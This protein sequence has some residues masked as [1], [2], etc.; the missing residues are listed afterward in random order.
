[1][2]PASSCFPTCIARFQG[3]G[4]SAGRPCGLRVDRGNSLPSTTPRVCLPEDRNDDA[5]DGVDAAVLRDVPGIVLG[6]E[7]PF[8]H[9]AQVRSADRV[10]LAR[11]FNASSLMALVERL[12]EG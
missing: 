10:W 11:P 12:L 9:R 3:R 5:Q 1:M 2:K 8:V 7:R 4:N 6:D